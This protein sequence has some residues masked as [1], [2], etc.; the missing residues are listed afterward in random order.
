MTDPAPDLAQRNRNCATGCV[1]GAGISRRISIR[2]RGSPLSARC[3][4]R[5]PSGWRRS[6]WSAVMRRGATNPTSCPRWPASRRAARLRCPIMRR[7]TP[8]WRS[9]TVRRVRRWCAGRGAHRNRA[10]TPK[11]RSRRSCSSRSSVSTGTAA[12][13]GRAAGITTASLRTTRPSPH[14]RRMVGAG[15]GRASV[16]ALD[17]PLDAIWTEQEFIPCGDRL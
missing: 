8:P 14:R 5:S 10:P 6:R 7:A 16:S 12:A 3:P 13:S 17:A 9:G 15:G 1:S 4:P 11:A 2:W